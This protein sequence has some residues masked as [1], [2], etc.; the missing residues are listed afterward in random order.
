MPEKTAERFVPS[1]FPSCPGRLYR[2]GD[3]GK[4]VPPEGNLQIIGRC[5]FMVK[6]RGYS[7]VLGAVEVAVMKHPGVASAVVLAEGDEANS[8]DK[9][10]IAYVV[11]KVLGQPPS[12]ASVRAFLKNE[13]PIYALPSVFLVLDALPVSGAQKPRLVAAMFFVK[14]TN[15]VFAKTGSGQT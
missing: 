9:R 2:T 10:L 14:Y 1:P 11:P 8:G 4:L 13:I 6:I 12:A 3:L 15:G 7:V 5:D